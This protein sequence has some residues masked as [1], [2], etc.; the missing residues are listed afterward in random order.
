MPTALTGSLIR[1]GNF[2]NSEIL[3]RPTDVAW[4]VTFV[5]VDAVPR[6]PVQLYEVFGYAFVF[7]GLLALYWR[8]GALPRGVLAGLFLINVFSVRMVLEPFKMPQ[9]A[10]AEQLPVL[11]VGQWLSLPFVVAGLMLT[12]YAVHTHLRAEEN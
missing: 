10:F 8:W 9:A 2:F 4:V 7:A 1:V 5:R 11:S 6:H 3:G 12:A